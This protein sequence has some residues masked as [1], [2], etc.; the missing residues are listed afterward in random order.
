MSQKIFE[1]TKTHPC[2]DEGAHHK[3][4]R[5]HLPIAPKCNIQCRYCNRKYDC[6]N[7]SRPGVTSRVLTPDEALERTRLVKEKIPQL[8]VVGI[9]GPGDPLANEETF[10]TL[11]KIREEFPELTICLS[12]NG[13]VLP[14]K[15]EELDKLGLKF[16]TITI[17][18]VDPKVGKNIYEWV[19]LNGRKY[20]GEEAARILISRQLKGLEEAVKRGMT[21]KVNTVMMPDINVEHIP[22]VCKKV[23]SLGAYIVNI[24]P[25]IP[26]P[27]TTIKS[28]APTSL[29]RK[30]L[31]DLCGADIR[32]M[33][34]CRFCRADAVGLLGEDRSA[35]FAKVPCVHASP[36]TA[37]ATTSRTVHL[38]AV[39]TS[40][41]GWVDLHFGQ[42]EV[43]HIYQATADSIKFV[44]KRDVRRYCEKP[45][46]CGSHEEKILKIIETLSGCDAVIAK[47]IGERPLHELE[48]AGIKALQIDDRVESAVRKVA[49]QL[50]GK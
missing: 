35:E 40:G 30:K 13:L 4:A 8:T 29:E 14:E 19:Y 39:A 46:S 34:H 20:E 24:L 33:R 5:V 38:I 7:E 28:R 25:L 49:S 2:Y 3:Y 12:T 21:V 17:N 9:A 18:A 42:A 6:V 43:F 11:S 44:G 15:I 22:E 10:E 1:K 31:Q 47:K 37:G 16:L 27:G 41:K 36:S 32:Q 23:K 45:L 26:V 50:M 48:K